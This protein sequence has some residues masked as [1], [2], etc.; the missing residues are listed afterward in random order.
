MAGHDSHHDCASLT[1]RP[2]V[3]RNSVSFGMIRYVSV[4]TVCFAVYS[5]VQKGQCGIFMVRSRII[6]F[7]QVLFNF[8]WFFLVF[9][10]MFKRGSVVRFGTNPYVSVC[11]S[12]GVAIFDNCSIQAV[13]SL[14]INQEPFTHVGAHRN[15]N[16]EP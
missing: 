2:Y 16:L 12:K 9:L 15:R 7:L 11:R 6:S 14:G 10:G 3:S 8:S 4:G 5:Y 13:K 1:Q